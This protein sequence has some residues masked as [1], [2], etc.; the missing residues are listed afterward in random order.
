MRSKCLEGTVRLLGQA[1]LRDLVVYCCI[2]KVT[3][4]EPGTV[5]FL[6]L[7]FEKESSE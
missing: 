5:K 2:E 3:S 4:E 1:Y 6:G 7:S